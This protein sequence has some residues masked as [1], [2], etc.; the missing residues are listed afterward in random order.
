M[1]QSVRSKTESVA[2][3]ISESLHGLILDTDRD[4]ELIA[5]S[6]TRVNRAMRPY[7]QTPPPTPREIWRL[8]RVIRKENKV[9]NGFVASI[10]SNQK[11]L[12]AAWDI[13]QSSGDPLRRDHA[14]SIGIKVAMLDYDL[15]CRAAGMRAAMAFPKK[16]ALELRRLAK[17]KNKKTKRVLEILWKVDIL[18]AVSVLLLSLTTGQPEMFEAMLTAGT[19]TLLAAASVTVADRKST[20]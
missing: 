20:D 7:S 6:M 4:V 8:S 1:S 16:C 10:R 11:K 3:D 15:K 13:L 14:E 2:P 17:S 18:L 5:E 9:Q 12:T 19:F